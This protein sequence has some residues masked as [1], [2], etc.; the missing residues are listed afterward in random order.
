[1]SELSLGAQAKLLHWNVVETAR[2]LDLG[3]SSVYS[4]I[5]AFGLER[6][7]Q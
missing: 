2:W 5:R 7:R 3:Q 6:K 1:V 4:R